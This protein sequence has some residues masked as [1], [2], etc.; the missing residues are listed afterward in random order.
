MKKSK[1]ETVTAEDL[2]EEERPSRRFDCGVWSRSLP[3]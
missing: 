1:I 3:L 2:G